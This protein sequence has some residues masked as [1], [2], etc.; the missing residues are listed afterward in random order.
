MRITHTLPKSV[1]I[2]MAL[3]SLFVFLIAFQPIFAAKVT[4]Q[5]DGD[6]L[7]TP[8]TLGTQLDQIICKAE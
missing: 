5:V 6:Y 1:L 3:S 4:P 7:N 8:N 2:K